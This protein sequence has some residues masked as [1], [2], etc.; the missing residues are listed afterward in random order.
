M[1]RVILFNLVN[2]VYERVGGFVGEGN[3]VKV[4]CYLGYNLGRNLIC[5][6]ICLI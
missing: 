5:V 1:L 3:R 2:F 6:V 4:I